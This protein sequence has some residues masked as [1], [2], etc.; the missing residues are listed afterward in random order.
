MDYFKLIKSRIII[1]SQ[2]IAI[3]RNYECLGNVCVLV[4]RQKLVDSMKLS[5]TKLVF[6]IDLKQLL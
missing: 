5:F 1:K 6:V 2:Q 4:I 3:H